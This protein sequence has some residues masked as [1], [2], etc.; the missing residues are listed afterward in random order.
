MSA[1]M[2][3]LVAHNFYQ[4]PGGEDGVFNDEVKLLRR[5]GHNVEIFTAHND[6]LRGQRA[7]PQLV[8]AVWNREIAHALGTAARAH[9]AEVVH[10]H[11]TFPLISPASYYAAHRAGAAVVQTLHNYR[12]ICPGALLYRQGAVCE[13]CVGAALPWRGVRHR[14]YRN[15]LT[16]SA[17]VALVVSAHRIRR[18]WQRKVDAY[19][20]LTEFGRAKFIEGGL[21]P[22]Q[23]SV[24]P[25]FLDP[26]PGA[27]AG[28]GEY[29]LFV[30]R[31]T[32][33]KGVHTL[34]DAWKQLRRLVPLRIVGDG[35]L[36]DEVQ[37]ATAESTAIEYLGQQ[38]RDVVLKLL[39]DAKFL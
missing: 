9:R 8:N 37:Q 35:P 1:P 15:S 14:C 12:L 10:F 22:E 36:R 18:T 23:I 6:D 28:A 32:E 13:Q 38:P 11:N 39:R 2:R 30:G 24:K 21:P 20:A 17:G 4:Q 34:L 16:A 27:G 19:I 7:L 33:D 5:F 3:V 29:A 31:L 26:D 25:N